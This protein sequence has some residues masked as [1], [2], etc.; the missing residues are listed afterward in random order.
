[1]MIDMT[2]ARTRWTLT[3]QSHELV[4]RSFKDTST[5]YSPDTGTHFTED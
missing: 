2:Q 4:I 3:L 1:M 5:Y